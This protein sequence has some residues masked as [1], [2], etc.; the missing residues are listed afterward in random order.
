MLHCVSAK[1]APANLAAARWAFP[2]RMQAQ[3]DASVQGLD[4]EK[5]FDSV[6]DVIKIADCIVSVSEGDIG[7]LADGLETGKE[8][9][10]RIY[11]MA[12]PPGMPPDLNIDNLQ[13]CGWD[14]CRQVLGLFADRAGER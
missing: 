5:M 9:G 10:K 8:L 6:V 11:E 12:T 7:A 1:V 4:W 3:K 2:G 13:V 14:I